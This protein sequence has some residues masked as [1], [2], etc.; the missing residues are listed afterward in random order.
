MLAESSA[1]S[2]MALLVPWCPLELA[3]AVVQFKGLN[4][5]EIHV[6]VGKWLWDKLKQVRV[7]ECGRGNELWYKFMLHLSS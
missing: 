7:Q 4:T 3:E 2:A 5:S 6:L 1:V